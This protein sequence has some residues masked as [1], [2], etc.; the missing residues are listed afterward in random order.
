MCPGSLNLRGSSWDEDQVVLTPGA[1]LRALL[2]GG[3]GNSHPW[4]EQRKVG[5]F[6]SGLDLSLRTCLEF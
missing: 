2:Q 3:C 1:L 6:A 5:V 4:R